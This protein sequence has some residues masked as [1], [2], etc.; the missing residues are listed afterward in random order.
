LAQN[1]QHLFCVRIDPAID[2]QNNTVIQEESRPIPWTPEENPYGNGYKTH[3]T[4]FEK[5]GFADAA[6]QH[7]RVFKIINRN[8][9]NPISGRPVA[10][11]FTPSPSQ[12]QLAHP[13]SLMARRSTYASHHVWVTKYRDGELYASGRWTNQSAREV[14]G[15]ADMAARDDDVDNEDIVVWHSFGL[16]H[17]PRTED[18]PVM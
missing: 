3:Q 6:P 15:V 18:F 10:Y 14:G 2:G 16:T 12:L 7:N 4:A 11:K 1:H 9:R 13:G 17:N 8:K 5:S